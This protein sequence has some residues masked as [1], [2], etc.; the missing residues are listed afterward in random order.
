MDKVN[1]QNANVKSN[2]KCQ[3]ENH[4]AKMKQDIADN[5]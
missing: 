4:C 5:L 1:C 2:H 3:E